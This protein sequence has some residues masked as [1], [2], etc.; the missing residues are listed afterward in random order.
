MNTE[1]LVTG[2]AGFIGSNI[3]HTLVSSGK[4]VRVL[5]N[6]STGRERN[7]S[8]LADGI[9]L[10]KG[11][12]RDVETVKKAVAGIRY[13][14]HLAALPS[15]S[16]SVADPVSTNDVNIG[17]TLNILVQAR[18]AGVERVVFSSSSS[19]YG[20]LPVLPKRE[21]MMPTPRS[22]YALSKLTGEHYAR[23]F[24]SLYGL[25]TFALRYFNVYGPRQDPKSQY[26]AVIPKFIG[27][28]S[29]DRAPTIHGD[30]GQ[31]RDF[32]FVDDVVNANLCCCTAPEKAAGGIFNVG[33]GRR[34]SVNDLAEK[35]ME[36][37]GKRIEP[38]H[39][40][41]Q[42]G[43]VRDSQAD[44]TRASELLGWSAKVVFDEGLRRTIDWFT[45]HE[46]L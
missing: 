3:V 17:G 27:A 29:A 36:I 18:D 21:D 14:L 2:G 34:V 11:D 38:V 4:R 12:I 25:K 15:V 10:V 23:L 28:L 6:L 31:T 24:F 8:D 43:D 13:I 44:Y 20:D 35:M 7:L 9:E 30:G 19:V 22:P 37:M 1:Y 26:A 39:D 46:T 32:T 40:A 41:P 16:R 45:R 5:D 33:G 42:P